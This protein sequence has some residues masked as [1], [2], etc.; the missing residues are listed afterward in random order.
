MWLDW[1]ASASA[2]KWSTGSDNKKKL[3]SVKYM[4]YVHHWSSNY[5][6]SVWVTV[7]QLPKALVACFCKSKQIAHEASLHLRLSTSARASSQHNSSTACQQNGGIA[8]RKWFFTVSVE[9]AVRHVR[10]GRKQKTS[11]AEADSEAAIA[12]ASLLCHKKNPIFP[13]QSS[14]GTRNRQQERNIWSEA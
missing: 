11:V 7:Q 2:V 6:L 10:Y 1:R 3:L 4:I 9:K 8:W 12:G 14:E 5:I 13:S